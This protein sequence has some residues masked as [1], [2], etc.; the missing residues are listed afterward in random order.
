[1]YSDDSILLGMVGTDEQIGY[2]GDA[3]D[4]S[5]AGLVRQEPADLLLGQ[6]AG[7]SPAS[8]T[9]A[10]TAPPCWRFEGA[11]YLDVI[12][13]KG[14]LDRS[15]IDTSYTGDPSRFVAAD[16]NIVSQGFV[17]AEP[18]IYE[19]EVNGWKKPV[20]FLLLD[21]EVPIYQNTL[22]IRAD[23]LEANRACLQRLI[24]L[25]QRSSIDYMK[26][27]GPVNAVL[28]DFT[29]EDQGRHADLGRRRRRRGP[30][31]GSIWASSAT[32]RTASSARTTPRAVQTLINDYGPVF[33]ARGK[34]R[35]GRPDS[36]RTW[37][38]T[39]SWTSPSTLR[40]LRLGL[41]LSNEVPIAETVVLARQAEALGFSEV[42]LP[43]SGHG[44]G[45][46]TRCR[47][48]WR[49][50]RADQNRYRDRQ[51]VLA[52]PV[53]DRDGSRRAGRGLGWAARCSV[54]ARRCGRCVRW[55]KPTADGA[56]A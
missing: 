22:A 35:Q 36:R 51:S 2:V 54:S 47:H 48:A 34:A 25:L 50:R 8:P 40:P 21:K 9:S 53:V 24:P 38:P 18:Y 39:S 31:D 20:K 42:W 41:G 15:Q 11:A 14:L 16:G 30:E 43:E 56:A 10:A 52:P 19:H 33:A 32:A 49:R 17:T 4:E 27:P 28:V 5:R 1:M 12:E 45:V 26:N 55:A 23:K 6:P 3:A 13:G 7:T 37:S 46:F 44:R 29:V